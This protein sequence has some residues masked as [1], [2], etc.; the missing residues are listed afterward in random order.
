MKDFFPEKFYCNTLCKEIQFENE[1]DVYLYA[2]ALLEGAHKACFKDSDRPVLGM[3]H[4]PF[5]GV[6]QVLSL[7][8]KLTRLLK[9]D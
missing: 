8:T 4:G 1:R 7:V 6:N 3:S 2:F 5:S 9:I